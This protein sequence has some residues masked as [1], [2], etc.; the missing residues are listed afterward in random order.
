MEMSKS[1]AQLLKRTRGRELQREIAPRARSV[2]RVKKEFGPLYSGESESLKKPGKKVSLEE[3]ITPLLSK[4]RNDIDKVVEELEARKAEVEAIEP[5]DEKVMFELQES[6][7]K[8]W[9]AE[10]K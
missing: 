5:D 3:F 8:Q 9:S 2:S 1:E 6:L 7:V 4:H 10:S